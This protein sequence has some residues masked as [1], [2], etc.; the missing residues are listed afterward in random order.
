MTDMFF[1]LFLLLVIFSNVCV[2]ENKR[3]E[4]RILIDDNYYTLLSRLDAL[5]KEVTDLKSN[6]ASGSHKEVAFMAELTKTITGQNH[7][8]YFDDV[9][10]NIGNAYNPHH[11][12]FVVPVNGT[13]QF[14]VTACS[15]AGHYIVL[16]LNANNDIL[17][18]VLAGDDSYGD[19]NSKV[20][21][22][23]LQTGDDVFVQHI[24]QG[25]N[26]LSASSYGKPSFTGVLLH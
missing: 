16:E 5:E 2:A 6:Y 12:T 18:K 15:T 20:F 9:K 26:L 8:I 22:A 7:H 11:G 14:S 3:E 17:G 13:Y 10:L 1:G 24:S 23:Q 4:K 25:D 19:C 21:L